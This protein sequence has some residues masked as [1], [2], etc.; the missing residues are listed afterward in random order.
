MLALAAND[1]SRSQSGSFGHD[2]SILIEAVVPTLPMLYLSFNVYLDSERVSIL[3]EAVVPTLPM[4][5][6]SFNVYLDS[7]RVSIL[8]EAV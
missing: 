2:L 7:E 5:Y 8:I 1:H 4:L 6:L 3:I